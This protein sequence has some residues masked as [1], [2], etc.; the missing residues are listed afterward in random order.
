MTDYYELSL[1][2]WLENYKTIGSQEKYAFLNGNLQI[3]QYKSYLLETFFHT[4]ENPFSQVLWATRVSRTQ[5]GLF[6]KML[7]HSISEVKHDL[8]AKNDFLA[9]KGEEKLLTC[10]P[11]PSTSLLIAHTY[12]AASSQSLIP[13]LAYLF[14]VEHLPT[15]LPKGF[16]DQLLHSGIPS[17]AIT[18]LKEH[19]EV[20]EYHNKIMKSYVESLLCSAESFEEMRYWI[21]VALVAHFNMILGAMGRPL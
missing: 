7:Q 6:T 15:N 3:P 18:F 5:H 9:L 8:L 17:S 1:N 13:Y 4:R 16:L 19:M 14:H 11:L 21:D 10:R 20:D 12:H 2:Y